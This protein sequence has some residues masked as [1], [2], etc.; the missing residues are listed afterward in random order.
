MK[1]TEM[2]GTQRR[3]PVENLTIE[4]KYT[5]ERAEKIEQEELITGGWKQLGEAAGGGKKKTA[6]GKVSRCKGWGEKI[7]EAKEKT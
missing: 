5:E 7:N 6:A 2:D 1:T 4:I 3:E